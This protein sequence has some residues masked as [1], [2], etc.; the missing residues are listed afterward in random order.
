MKKLWKDKLTLQENLKKR[1][2]KL[3]KRYF[4]Q[5]R[6]ALTPG[7]SWEEMHEFRLLTKRF[8]YTLETFKD[9]YGPAMKQ[10]IE[11]LRKVQTYLGDINDCIVT[12]AL[13][14][15]IE[16]MDQVRSKLAADADEITAKLRTYWAATFDADGA[17]RV[18]TRYLVT[19]AA[20]PPTAPRTRRLPAPE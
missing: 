2:P 16:G 20:V 13:L 14:E 15:P 11:S 7:T 18:W 3:A 17:E 6:A 4:K 9:L 8:R 12:A 10:R 1:M 19:H 5:G